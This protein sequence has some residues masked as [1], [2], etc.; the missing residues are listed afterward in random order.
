[1]PAIRVVAAQGLAD[2]TRA[3]EIADEADIG[4]VGFPESQRHRSAVGDEAVAR[5]LVE[6][7]VSEKPEAGQGYR[8]RGRGGFALDRE[9]TETAETGNPLFQVFPVPEEIE[10]EILFDAMRPIFVGISGGGR[11]SWTE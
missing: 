3:G 5:T 10:V 6:D 11:Q 9:K 8:I 1:M 7:V 4:N 2:F